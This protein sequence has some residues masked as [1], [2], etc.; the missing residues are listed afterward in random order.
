MTA[1]IDGARA[2]TPAPAIHQRGPAANCPSSLTARVW[3]MPRILTCS[4]HPTAD[5]RILFLHYVSLSKE[6]NIDSRGLTDM[7]HLSTAER[8]SHTRAPPHK[9]PFVSRYGFEHW[10]DIITVYYRLS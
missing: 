4:M 1:A 7:E 10:S 2:H 5:S 9:L 8:V 3:E 6:L